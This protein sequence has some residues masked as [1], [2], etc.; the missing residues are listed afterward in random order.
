MKIGDLKKT[1]IE[2]KAPKGLDHLVPKRKKYSVE[3]SLSGCDSAVPNALRRTIM[4]EMHLVGLNCTTDDIATDDMHLFEMLELLVQRFKAISVDQDT[5][6][7]C[8]FSIDVKN[9]T[10]GVMAVT[11]GSM[12][13]IAGPKLKELPCE[14]HIVL[15]DLN[16][17]KYFRCTLR[18]DQLYNSERGNG[19]RAVASGVV[20][21]L[22]NPDDAYNQ[23]TGTGTKVMVSDHRKWV[24]AFDT[25]GTMSPNDIITEACDQILRRLR[26]V[27]SHLPDNI[28]TVGDEYRLLIEDTHTIGEPIVR[29]IYDTQTDIQFVALE[30]DDKANNV[31]LRLK[32]TG[33][34]TE[35]IGGAIDAVAADFTSI[36]SATRA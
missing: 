29:R 15:F 36:R 7:S 3:I 22:K 31:T 4:S 8:Q 21:R 17:H 10:N 2:V 26:G 19:G 32:T 34:A 18:V 13:Q 23:Y 20:S 6:L 12:K 27:S 30:H 14:S 1:P 11:A 35:I 24:L 25:N 16:P 28:T 33:T 9:E 5:A